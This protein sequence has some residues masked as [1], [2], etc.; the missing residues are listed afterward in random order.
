M[1][2]YQDECLQMNVHGYGLGFEVVVLLVYLNEVK[3]F[4]FTH[5]GL[6]YMVKLG[7]GK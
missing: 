6:Q 1:F 5:S 4:L 2:G 3:H 7:S